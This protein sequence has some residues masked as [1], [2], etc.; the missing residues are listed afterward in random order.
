MKAA[1]PERGRGFVI[2]GNIEDSPCSLDERC[3]MDAD[4]KTHLEAMEAR[5]DAR[6]D[7]MD[8]RFDRMDARLDG[9]DA[10]LDGMDARSEA[11]EARFKTHVSVECEKIETKLLTEF[12]KWGRVSEIRTRQAMT[13]V[14][15]LGE[16][17]MVAEERIS[18]LERGDTGGRR[19]S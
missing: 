18:A 6:F 13:D 17:M 1:V 5:F 10:R 11:M 15:F 19:T 2:S 12:H 9:M 4:L 16:R 8:A 14:A 7:G 3:E